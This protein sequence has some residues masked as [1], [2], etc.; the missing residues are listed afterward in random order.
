[1]LINKAIKRK[2]LSINPVNIVVVKSD[3]R[4]LF[5]ISWAKIISILN[6]ISGIN[7]IDIICI[8]ENIPISSG[9]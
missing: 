4:V 6:P 1:M 2:M 8:E 3:F 9:V 7:I 5:F